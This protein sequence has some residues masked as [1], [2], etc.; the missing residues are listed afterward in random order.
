MHTPTAS[1]GI[2]LDEM[3]PTDT[4]REEASSFYRSTLQVL[5]Q[6]GLEALVGGA[7]ALRLHAG[8]ER[9]TKDFDLFIRPRDSDRVIE[10]F[11]AAGYCAGYAY[12][13][14]LVKV[15]GEGRY[16][17]IIY[18]S[19]NGLCDVDDEWFAF[20]REDAFFGVRMPVC[21]PEEMLWQKAF[22]MERERY[23]G[24]DVQHLLRSCGATMDWERV[25]RRFGEDWRV[26]LSH[27]VLFGY[28]Y[29]SE[30]DS[31]P[32]WV[33]AHLTTK[34]NHRAAEPAR[35]RVCRGTLLSRLQY[36]EDIE[37]WGYSDPRSGSAVSMSDF[38]VRQWSEE[39]KDQASFLMGNA[40]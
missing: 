3:Q 22:V 2:E 7:F 31:I 16:L 1:R 37:K 25:L 26:L 21:P 40:V 8:V 20:A 9:D 23:D 13:H 39:A 35:E 17:D 4:H 12:S 19:G 36:L 14:W 27:L 32:A 5:R 30:Q 33:M 11:R 38:E 28:V 34:L 29:P 18:R 10:A 24:A 15:H 6:A